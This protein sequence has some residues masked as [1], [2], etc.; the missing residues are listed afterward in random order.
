MNDWYK[1]SFFFFFFLTL[2][3][4]VVFSFGNFGFWNL[5][6]IKYEIQMSIL[7]LMFLFLISMVVINIKKNLHN[8]LFWFC[9]YFFISSIFYLDVNHV[10]H[11]LVS[12]LFVMSLSF[13]SEERIDYIIKIIIFFSFIFS[14]LGIIQWVILLM[15][16]GGVE[17]INQEFTSETQYISIA[18]Q[19][20][21][22]YLSWVNYY[23]GIQLENFF[24]LAY[25]RSRSFASEPSVLVAIFF[26][27]S[28]LA[29]LYSRKVKFMGGVILFYCTIVV[30]A[31]V[32]H[33]SIFLGLIVYLAIIFFRNVKVVF[34]FCFLTP[35]IWLFA[36]P[37]ILP[38]MLFF[39][40]D[41][42]TGSGLSRMLFINDIIEIFFL[43]P[44]GLVDPRKLTVGLI[45]SSVRVFPIFGL[46]LAIC[47]FYTVLRLIFVAS[48]RNKVLF[49]MFGGAF[50][51]V[52]IFSAYGWV[53]LPG[54][55]IMTLTFFKIKCLANK[56]RHVI[57]MC[58]ERGL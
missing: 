40:P 16:P 53:T 33:L 57:V 43:N 17:L 19:S 54:F 27:P 6:G 20:Y 18:T 52:F 14:L 48:I 12:L 8:I 34:V 26:I 21:L 55:I 7:S 15:H 38:Y 29:F 50:I 2:I 5:F 11:M 32:M 10:F 1:N 13:L 24:G 36:M 28:L 41:Y 51:Q 49:S 42:K 23:D 3:P 35:L 30:Y 31:G 47:F 39:L 22:D 45:L 4:F 25:P 37:V 58:N 44:L 56:S 9:L 46:G